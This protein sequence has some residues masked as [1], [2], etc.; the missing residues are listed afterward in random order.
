MPRLAA[1]NPL[2]NRQQKPR[3]LAP[4]APGF[5]D[6]KTRERLPLC[7]VLLEFDLGQISDGWRRSF[8]QIQG[9]RIKIARRGKSTSGCLL[10]TNLV[11]CDEKSTAGA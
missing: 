8:K 6:A 1:A 2:R 10:A 4:R 11:G 7:A 9:N 5:R 3:D